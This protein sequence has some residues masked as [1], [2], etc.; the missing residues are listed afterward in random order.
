M[1][2]STSYRIA[3]DTDRPRP[4]TTDRLMPSTPAPQS[5]RP[6]GCRLPE[7]GWPQPKRRP[8][9]YVGSTLRSSARWQ[10]GRDL[11]PKAPQFVCS[12][13]RIPNGF[14]AGSAVQRLRAAWAGRDRAPFG[15]REAPAVADLGARLYVCGPSMAHF[16]VAAEDLLP[17]GIEIAACP[18]VCRADERCQR[19]DLPPVARSAPP[20]ERELRFSARRVQPGAR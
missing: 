11:L 13:G 9:M 10:L 3:V 4:S 16:R 1:P 12:P 7:H 2:R 6:L 15:P 18:T 17:P 14:R 19:P 20:P 5:Q 8:G